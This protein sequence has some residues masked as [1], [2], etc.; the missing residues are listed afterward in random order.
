MRKQ[1][2]LAV[3]ASLLFPVCCFARAGATY[4]PLPHDDGRA[5]A[6]TSRRKAAVSAGFAMKAARD[7]A[8]AQKQEALAKEPWRVV[9][10]VTNSIFGEGWYPLYRRARKVTPE[11]ILVEG[12]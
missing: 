1:L 5:A 12:T 2:Y 8:E 6:E 3:L 4:F 10:G 9:D 7:A 11:G